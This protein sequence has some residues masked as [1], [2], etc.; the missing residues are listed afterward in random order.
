MTAT[1]SAK[2][3]RRYRYYVCQ[4]VRQKG[5]QS[6]LTKSVSATVIED[7]VVFQI[8]DRLR[9]DHAR[10]ELQIPD[11]ELAAFLQGDPTALIQPLVEKIH[12]DGTTGDVAIQLRALEGARIEAQP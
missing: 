5:W 6:C 4:S 3:K 10:V 9:L 7:S 2:G 8:R 12:Y 1:Y 11:S